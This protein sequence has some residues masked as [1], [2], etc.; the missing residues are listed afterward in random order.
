ELAREDRAAVA[1]LRMLSAPQDQPLADF[2]DERARLAA[3]YLKIPKPQAHPATLGGRDALELKYAGNLLAGRP[4]ECR[5]IYTPVGSQVLEVV[6]IARTG[7]P[8]APGPKDLE[9][10]RASIRF[11]EP[12]AAGKK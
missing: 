4:A 6:L 8:G 11:V 1:V 7:D 3:E 10:I 5:A 2:V 9:T 12:P